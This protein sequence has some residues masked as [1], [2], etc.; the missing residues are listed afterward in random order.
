MKRSGR[1][2]GRFSSRIRAVPTSLRLSMFMTRAWKV[3]AC[4]SV[5]FLQGCSNDVRV[6]RTAVASESVDADT[7]TE[8]LCSGATL[9]FG[10]P[11]YSSNAMS[12]VIDSASRTTHIGDL[13]EWTLDV[14]DA[15]G[16]PVTTGTKVT[17]DCTM[18]HAQFAHGCPAHIDV[19]EVAPGTYDASPIVFNMQGGWLVDIWIGGTTEVTVHVCAD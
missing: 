12:V 4:V 6:L 17:V 14:A 10:A 2:I 16:A 5:F 11:A 15:M 8:T 9:T 3:A 1:L 19:N 7:V 18:L 13:N